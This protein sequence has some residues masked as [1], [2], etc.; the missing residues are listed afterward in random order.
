MTMYLIGGN[1][2]EPI[3]KEQI[4]IHAN[5]FYGYGHSSSPDTVFVLDVTEK[6]VTFT[7]YPYSKDKTQREQL[8]LFKC[9]AQKGTQ[10]QLD[11]R[12]KM[13][14]SGDYGEPTEETRKIAKHY[15]AVLNGNR[16]ESWDIEDIRHVCFQFSYNG[17]EDGWYLFENWY[18]HS[19][20]GAK[21]Q[22]GK[23]V[24]ET[25]DFTAKEAREIRDM[26]ETFSFHCPG[27]EFV[28][29]T[30]YANPN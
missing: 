26:M 3:G 13:L 5:A 21:E 18:P 15:D 12:I 29:I 7:R 28:A 24:Y 8:V 4:N 11:G 22:D 14:M 19:I 30:D 1:G 25:F 23:L 17:D 27:F 16:G 20:S 9:G 10:T 2:L 6:W